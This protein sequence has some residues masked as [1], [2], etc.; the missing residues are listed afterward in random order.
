MVGRWAI[1]SCIR[2]ARALSA[3]AGVRYGPL[4]GVSESV[5]AFQWSSGAPGLVEYRLDDGGWIPWATQEEHGE[6]GDPAPTGTIELYTSDHDSIEVRTSGVGEGAALFVVGG[7]ERSR[8][9]TVTAAASAAVGMPPMVSREAWGGA[10]C[11]DYSVDEPSWTNRVRSVV[12]HHTA[13]TNSYS[14]SSVP[15]ILQ[16][17][18]DYHTSGNGWTDIG[19][20]FLIDRFG[21][22]Y[23]GRRSNAQGDLAVG[24]HVRGINS[25]TVGVALLGDFRSA[26]P[27]VAAQAALTQLLTWLSEQE[28][29]NP[30]AVMTLT[31]P[32]G[33]S[34]VLYG[35]SGHSDVSTTS[36]PGSYCYNLLPS[37]RQASDAAAGPRAFIKDLS[38]D[39]PNPGDTLFADFRFTEHVSW[40]IRITD[41]DGAQLALTTGS[42][43]TASHTMV[44]TV[45]MEEVFLDLAATTTSSGYAPPPVRLSWHKHYLGRFSDD[46]ESPHQQSI[47][48]IAAVGI[49]LGCDPKDLTLYCP[50]KE[51]TRAQM[52]T[53]IVRALGLPP[54]PR[55]H[56]TDDN[57]HALEASIN[58]FA[59][60]GITYGCAT[61]LF[62]PEQIVPREQMAAFLARAL[63][64]PPSP[65]NGFQDVT[66]Y[67]APEINAMAAAGIIVACNPE[68]TLFCPAGLVTR[69]SMAVF[70]DKGFLGG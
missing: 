59:E 24:A 28:H 57:G 42:G 10:G 7:I 65:T 8:A 37:F 13:G 49:T 61:G 2:S 9:V 30:H 21:T 1:R 41:Q 45:G 55:D 16:A 40:T 29:I 33:E 20:N 70:L 31:S 64:L 60:S 62:C 56:F 27:T 68:G 66:G 44:M 26:T 5:V 17:V 32:E 43:Q 69:E 25:Q 54:S 53:F 67:F 50:G 4:E 36:C 52:A 63:K 23:E 18:C 58:A 19:Y 34:H 48:R 39:H 35:I 38:P 46:D 15:G 3:R 12:I 51:V 14:A 11:E 47:E 6:D 22:I